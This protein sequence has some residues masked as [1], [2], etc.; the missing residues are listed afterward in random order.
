MMTKLL[1]ALL[2][3][4]LLSVLAFPVFIKRMDQLQ[5]GQQIREDGPA[6]HAQKSGTPT[7][8]G[9]VIIASAMIAS[10]FTAG[11]AKPL[12][13][14]LPVF[15][16]C[17]L[18]GF[19]DDY[20][21]IVKKQSLGFKARSKL[22]GMLII[23]LVFMVLLTLTDLYNPVVKMPF[24][25]DPINF[26]YIYP[27]F[28]LLLITGFSNSVNLTDGIDGLAAGTAALALIAFAYIS[29]RAG[30]PSVALFCAALTGACFGFLVFNRHPARLFMGDVGSLALGGVLAAV[31]VVAAADLFLL[32]IGAVFVLEA[33]S[34]TLQVASFQL[35]GKR[36]FLMSPLHHH[37]ELK[38]WS[39]WRVVSLFWFAGLLFAITG[40][41]Q[42]SLAAAAL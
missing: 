4:F 37:F 19:L 1:I 22:F 36:I 11:L 13:V 17:G 41:W 38:G 9:L 12:L 40:I 15:L 30:I 8:G 26:G 7:M 16:G 39:E 35:T 33:L 23:S 32:I 18:L 5:F 31:A 24:I 29:Y 20:L 25:T 2:L 28:V 27:F 34:V 14:V 6:R 10:L 3:A 21:K 42:Y